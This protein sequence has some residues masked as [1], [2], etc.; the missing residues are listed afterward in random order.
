MGCLQ[1]GARPGLR[2][3][4]GLAADWIGP[5]RRRTRIMQGVE[6]RTNSRIAVVIPSYRVTRHV[7]DVI[8]RIGSEVERIYVVDDKCPDDSGKFV[9]ANCPDSRVIIISNEVNQGVGGAVLAGYSAAI[10]DRMDI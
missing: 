4:L 10:A 2:A 8:S 9:Q 1:Q 5:T 3:R 6:T 7:L